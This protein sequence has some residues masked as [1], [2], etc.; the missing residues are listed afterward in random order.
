MRHTASK[1]TGVEQVRSDSLKGNL[2]SGA[3]VWRQLN[4]IPRGGK[5]FTG[6]RRP[7]TLQY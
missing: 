1:S 5:L 3:R 6:R 4:H 7:A 2:A